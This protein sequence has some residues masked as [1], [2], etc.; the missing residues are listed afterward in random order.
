MSHEPNDAHA[1]LI[2]Q[3]LGSI[4]TS[5]EFRSSKRCQDLLR[6]LVEK[7]LH[8]NEENLKERMIASDVFGLKITEFEPN[9]SSIVRVRACEVRKKLERYYETEGKGSAIRIGL[10]GSYNP[11]FNF[12]QT[13]VVLREYLAASSVVAGQAQGGKPKLP[14]RPQ[15]RKKIGVAAIAAS[16]FIACLLV[17][18]N[19]I[20]D[21]RDVLS[22]F[23]TP[24]VSNTAP[25]SL[26]VAPVPVYSLNH[27]PVSSSPVMPAEF[28]LIRDQYVAASDVGALFRVAAILKQ[29]KQPYK[30][31]IG[32]SMSFGDL[33]GEP[34]VVIGYT[35]S[36]WKEVSGN[37]RYR[38]RSEAPPFGI[39]DRNAGMSWM[40]STAP[41]DP[42]LKE[43]YAIISRSFQ[44]DTQAP[45]VELAGIS[46]FGTEAAGELVTN[47]T[48]L[49]DAL[50]HAPKG[51]QRQNLQIVI[52]VKVIDG[53]PS[54]PE[55]VATYFW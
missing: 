33:R 32:S 24:V 41:N 25:V 47:S 29:L 14:A 16:V 54:A 10:R 48:M 28:G 52:H 30:L 19:A 44:P 7:K 13:S 34:A 46:H 18:A 22:E 12:V 8:G 20:R 36:K 51:W 39:V 9:N 27:N 1:H 2:K 45:L 21:S 40:L 37:C 42:A 38:I 50:Q 6:Y 5:R 15:R 11:E 55:V 4:L 3:A 53:Y 43:D 31:H 26:F 17:V 35:Y 23:W 49:R